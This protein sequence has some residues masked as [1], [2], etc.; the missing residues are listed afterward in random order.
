MLR[1]IS[2]LLL[3]LTGLNCASYDETS[4][5][6]NTAI[7]DSKSMIHWNYTSTEI[8]IK[9]TIQT[10]GWVGFGLSPNGG[11][12]NSDILLA[13]PNEFRDAHVETTTQII[14]DKKMNWQRL[15]YSQSSGA[16]TVIFK[17]KIIICDKD[18]N[19]ININV[20][21]TSFVIYAYGDN[22]VNGLP[23]YHG[24]SNR[25]SKSLPLLVT[26]KKVQLDM[27]TIET[28]DFKTS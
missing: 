25:G 10:T 23:T 13:W 27:T 19:E 14:Y 4:L 22:F 12:L 5:F 1:N 26:N 7:L 6:G 3:V 21:P 2:L 15:F 8:I 24:T 17:R 9:L 18:S 28:I 11:M 20:E 16:T